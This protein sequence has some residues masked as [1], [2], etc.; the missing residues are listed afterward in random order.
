MNRL[1]GRGG[2]GWALLLALAVHGLVLAVFWFWDGGPRGLSAETGVSATVRVLALAGSPKKSPPPAVVSAR[3]EP[4][5]VP[6][7]RPA[8]ALAPVPETGDNSSNLEESSGLTTVSGP[9]KG[10]V[11]R[12]LAEPRPAYPTSAR[13]RGLEGW[14]KLLYQIDAAGTILSVQ[15]E[16]SSHPVFESSALESARQ[17]RFSALV[18]ASPATSEPFHLL[19]RFVLESP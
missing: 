11:S 7:S 10:Q 9:G 19:V 14:V 13:R 2:W 18:G 6:A 4:A 3:T 16:A 1:P 8:Q 17:A 12:L 15:V 5:E